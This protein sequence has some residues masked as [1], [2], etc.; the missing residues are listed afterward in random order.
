MFFIVLFVIE[1]RGARGIPVTFATAIR[2]TFL[3]SRRHGGQG[4]GVELFSGN[5]AI[6]PWDF[7]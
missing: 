5:R 4:R 2:H 1:P 3:R 7:G 6:G